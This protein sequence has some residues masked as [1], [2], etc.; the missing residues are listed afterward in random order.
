MLS[1]KLIFL[2]WSGWFRTIC[3][4][5]VLIVISAVTLYNYIKQE[6]PEELVV[7]THNN[8][9]MI[10]IDNDNDNDDDETLTGFMFSHIDSD[11]DSLA[12][13]SR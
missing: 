10:I 2:Y 4:T 6:A 13:Q 7:K 11:I 5:Q 1:V 9:E 3:K 12:R 8:D